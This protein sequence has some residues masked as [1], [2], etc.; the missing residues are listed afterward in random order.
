MRTF[1]HVLYTWLLANIIFLG[2]LFWMQILAPY[3]KIEVDTIVVQCVGVFM[4]L[5]LVSLPSFLI[6][7]ALFNI[8]IIT[9]N[10]GVVKLLLWYLAT[11]LTAIFNIGIPIVIMIGDAVFIFSKVFMKLS[12]FAASAV[13][14]AITIRYKYFLNINN[15]YKQQVNQ[16]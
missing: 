7:M 13:I 3:S 10:S 5:V 11:T 6:S 9:K 16:Q 1:N 4:F 8:I 14:P 15:I 12:L 2:I